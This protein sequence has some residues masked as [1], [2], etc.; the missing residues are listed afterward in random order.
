MSH[1]PSSPDSLDQALTPEET[2]LLRSPT[3]AARLLAALKR[4]LRNEGAPATVDDL[5]REMGL[6]DQT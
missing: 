3:N 2:H 4:A 6:T 1:D 5:R